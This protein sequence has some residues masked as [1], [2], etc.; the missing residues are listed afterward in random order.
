MA[1]FLP[2]YALSGPSGELFR[3]MAD[4]TIFALA[5]SLL[6]AL[7]LLPVLCAWVLRRGV[8]ER[9]NVI[10]DRI[11]DAYKIGLDYSLARPWTVTI[12]S[13]AIFVA[14]LLLIPSIGDYDLMIHP[15]HGDMMV[16][17]ELV[18]QK[19]TAIC[20]LSA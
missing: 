12:V 20:R 19:L 8:R 3:P 11:R 4:T 18:R 14:S 7:T 2:I 1:G 15:A 17:S 16:A 6:I 5:G 10:F 13:L 9:R